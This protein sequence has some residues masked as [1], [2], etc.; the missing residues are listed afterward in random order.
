MGSEVSI[1]QEGDNCPPPVA[2]LGLTQTYG[3]RRGD[4]V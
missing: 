2:R 4:S 1:S 3:V